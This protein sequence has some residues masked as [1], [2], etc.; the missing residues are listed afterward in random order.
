MAS[1]S[2]PMRTHTILR[3]LRAVADYTSGVRLLA[4]SSGAI[5]QL[6]ERLDRTQEVAGSSPASSISKGPCTGA[7]SVGT[8]SQMI[9]RDRRRFEA[10]VVPETARMAV[11]V[12][13]PALFLRAAHWGRRAIVATQTVSRLPADAGITAARAVTRGWGA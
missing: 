8:G 13:F 1:S 5:A 7:D 2:S 11:D 12:G 9:A 4:A 3:M 6:G 10:L